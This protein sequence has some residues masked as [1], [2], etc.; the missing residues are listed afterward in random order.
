M[1]HSASARRPR[2][3]P[4][5]WL[6]AGAVALGIGAAL[7][8][9]SAV[10][11]ADTGAGSGSGKTS[12]STAHSARSSAATS[13]SA[14]ASS[15]KASAAAASNVTAADVV[16]TEATETAATTTSGSTGHS[17][18]VRV[19]AAQT[20]TSSTD[21][22]STA[23]AVPAADPSPNMNGYLPS[24]PIVA[25]VAV[26]L[27]QQQIADARALLQQQTWGSG[28]IPAGIVA[29]IPEILLAQAA[30][31]LDT[32][33]NTITPAQSLYAKTS[34]VPFVHELAGVSLLGALLL[35]TLATTALNS[36]GLFLP[37][38]GAFEGTGGIT[39]VQNL[40]STAAMNGRVYALVPVTMRATTEPIV[41]IS[42]NGGPSTPVLV[43]T[44]SSGLVVT[45]ASVGD[46]APLGSPTGTGSS[47]YSGGLSYD[48]T[49]YTTTVNFGNGIVSGP[50][51]VN[52][53]DA[54]DAATALSFFHQLGGASGVLGIGANAAG[55]GPS[56]PTTAL[57]GELS[58]GVF[59]YQGLFLGIAGVMVFGPN[60][61]PV[62]TSVSGAPDAYLNVKINSGT[63]TQ[64]GAIIDSGGVYGTILSSQ[65]GG[66]GSVPV[67][68]RI[69][70]Y[71]PDGVLL[72]SYIVTSQNRP[73]VITSGLINTG[74]AP[75]QH[76]PVYINYT[77][78]DG[79]GST[80]FD[81]A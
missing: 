40:V 78:P 8:S 62:R 77:A 43:D 23:A 39:P 49:T 52:I 56:I 19:A 16:D 74:Y 68:T 41:Y 60:P 24:E 9:G 6:G 55:P 37:L 10:A 5:A 12:S 64:V 59:L 17:A 27:A 65:I 48:Y 46:S 61:L 80:D 35:P 54:D 42:I 75:F 51:S 47:G 29:V 3:Q 81:Y 38:V 44:G 21:T 57:P 20:T 26:N 70:V 14:K 4:Y 66:A 32:W 25:G 69:S 15:R 36:A 72:Y 67:G 50:T 31:S 28:N 22:S 58:D 2:R 11:S 73:T 45:M 33:E 79:I 30:L 7:A 34:G 18:R 76:G 1:Q 63:P 53:V 71:T 13:S